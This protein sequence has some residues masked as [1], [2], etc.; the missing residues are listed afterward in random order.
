MKRLLLPAACLLLGAG[1]A[2]AFEREV[3]NV[4]WAVYDNYN[5]GGQTACIAENYNDYPVQAVFDV[6]PAAT[7]PD[8]APAPAHTAVTL[9]PFQTQKI[10]SWANIPGPGPSCELRGALT[11]VP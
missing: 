6:F 2:L 11:Q 3:N 4:W 7:D 10:W 9:A 5:G 1:P 8:G